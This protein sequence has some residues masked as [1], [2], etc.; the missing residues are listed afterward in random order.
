MGRCDYHPVLNIY[1]YILPGYEPLGLEQQTDQRPFA[2]ILRG[3]GGCRRMTRYGQNYS[4]ARAD[5]FPSALIAADAD[6]TCDDTDL[7]S[8]L[9]RIRHACGRRGWAVR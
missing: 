1:Y 2:K 4:T 8:G 9:F 5:F 6:G 3:A 7:P